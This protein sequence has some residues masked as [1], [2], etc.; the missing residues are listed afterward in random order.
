MYVVRAF[1][2]NLV[3][4]SL[5]NHKNHRSK[6]L[7]FPSGQQKSFISKLKDI[8]EIIYQVPPRHVIIFVSVEH[9]QNREFHQKT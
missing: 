4:G 7:L 3:Y 9:S 2:N 8:K 1:G 6:F 5:I